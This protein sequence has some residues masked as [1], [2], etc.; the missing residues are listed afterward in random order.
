M[1]P[2]SVNTILFLLLANFISK[3]AYAQIPN[4]ENLKIGKSILVE[5]STNQSLNAYKDSLDKYN[6]SLKSLAIIEDLCK[7]YP[8]LKSE[9]HYRKEDDVYDQF[10]NKPMGYVGLVYDVSIKKDSVWVRNTSG[11]RTK[12]SRNDVNADIFYPIFKRP[13]QPIVLVE[14][15]SAA[16][17]DKN[18]ALSAKVNSDT[19]KVDLSIK[20]SVPGAKIDAADHF[21]T[22]DNSPKTVPP[23]EKNTGFIEVQGRNIAYYN[24]LQ[25][26]ELVAIFTPYGLKEGANGHFYISRFNELTKGWNGTKLFNSKYEVIIDL[27]TFYSSD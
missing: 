12:L 14:K 23:K 6:T 21:I 2:K 26:D 1:L 20:R 22:I 16:T 27:S 19:A 15:E 5:N 13:Q 10:V 4:Q 7:K 17:L 3:E 24:L 9:F 11:T 8:I 25:K 18:M